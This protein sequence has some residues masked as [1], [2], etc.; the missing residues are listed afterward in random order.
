VR[1]REA[2]RAEVV[3]SIL[4]LEL[5]CA[6]DVRVAQPSAPPC[7]GAPPM[8]IAHERHLVYAAAIDEGV[9]IEKDIASNSPALG[10][11]EQV[12]RETVRRLERPGGRHAGLDARGT[13]VEGLSHPVANG[14]TDARG[15]SPVHA[16]PVRIRHKANRGL[17]QAWLVH[18]PGIP[19]FKFLI[20]GS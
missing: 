8:Q 9:S 17:I 7:Q 12:P 13:V 14:P 10:P 1:H 16:T 5:G 2:E 6:H 19:G 3:V 20:G 11:C 18:V 15:R 4:G